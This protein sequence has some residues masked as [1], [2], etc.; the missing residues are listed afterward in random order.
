MTPSPDQFD[1]HCPLSDLH[2]SLRIVNLPVFDPPSFSDVNIYTDGSKFDDNIGFSICI[3]KHDTLDEVFTFKLCKGNTVF[4]A[5]LAAIKFAINWALDNNLK[6][7]IFSDSL[8]SILALNSVK[9]KSKFLR[10]IKSLAHNSKTL[11]NLNWIKAH[12]GNIGNEMADQHAKL[13]TTSGSPLT[14]PFPYSFLSGHCKLLILNDW[15]SLLNNYIS[16]RTQD[17]ARILDY[18]PKVN[19][20]LQIYNKYLIYFLTGHGPFLDY[21]HYFKFKKSSNCLC[22]S[23]GDVDHYVFSCPFSKAFHLSRPAVDLRAAWFSGV[24]KSNILINKLKNCILVARDISN[25]VE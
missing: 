5:E 23:F 12:A 1:P 2:P 11:I 24:C 19:P 22:N 14:I 7:N 17:P 10:E 21:L 8:S 9:N 4:Q 20:G 13:A 15:Q 18:L 16:P 25:K 6:V 3:F